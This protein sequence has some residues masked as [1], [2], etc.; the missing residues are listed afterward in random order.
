M[1]TAAFIARARYDADVEGHLSRERYAAP[2]MSRDSRLS[3]RWET[4]DAE[5]MRA[6]RQANRYA[7]KA[8][9][10]GVNTVLSTSSDA[11][12]AEEMMKCA[13]YRCEESSASGMVTPSAGCPQ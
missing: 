12:C 11:A 4:V 5:T 9:A 8:R 6:W 13:R 2:L 3:C 7:A 1:R 10:A